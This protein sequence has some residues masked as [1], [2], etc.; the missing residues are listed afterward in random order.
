MVNINRLIVLWNV[1]ILTVVFSGFNTV[2]AIDNPDSP[3]LLGEFKAREQPYLDNINKSSNGAWNY[4]KT[5]NNYQDFLDRELNV[6]YQSIRSHL[7]NERK[8]ELKTSQFNWI[9]FRDSEFEFINNV[10]TRQHFGSSSDMSRGGYRCTVIRNR[11]MQ[12]LNY[13]IN[14]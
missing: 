10:W 12:L 4:L 14:F 5:Y 11:I 3:D 13:Q 1:F 9:K 2:Y 8:I 6:A 7:S